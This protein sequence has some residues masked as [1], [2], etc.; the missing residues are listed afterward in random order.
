MEL[1]SVEINGFEKIDSPVLLEATTINHAVNGE[2]QTA[3]FTIHSDN[4]GANAVVG[5]AIVGDALVGDGIVV[6]SEI[7]VEA[8]AERIFAGRISQMKVEPKVGSEI[9]FILTCQDYTWLL[10][11]VVIDTSFTGQSDQDIIQSLFAANLPEISVS[12]AV[13]ISDLSIAFEDV[14][15]RGAMEMITERTGADWYV[16]FFKEL[17]YQSPGALTAPFGFSD[18]PNGVSTFRILREGFSASDD[19]ST[20]ANTVTVKGREQE[21]FV[22]LFPVPSGNDDAMILK[23]GATFPPGGA[24][25][26]QPAGAMTASRSW[27]GSSYEII[28]NALRF[29]T[30]AIP[31]DCIVTSAVLVVY[32]DAAFGSDDGGEFGIEYYDTA[33][34]PLD[35]A[36]YTDTAPATANATGYFLISNLTALGTYRFTLSNLSNI[37]KT[38]YTGF[39]CHVKVSGTPTGNNYTAFASQDH[40][41]AIRPVLEVHY[42]RPEMTG[43]YTDDA[44]VA[45][46]GTLS[47]T[48]IERSVE[49]ED[50]ANLRAEYETALHAFPTKLIT[51]NWD[52]DGIK[53]DYSV[54]IYHPIFGLDG[55]YVC[56]KLTMKW[57]T[58]SETLYQGEL[59]QP[60]PDLVRLIR[61]LTELQ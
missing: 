37:N 47:R 36:D 18:N 50:E 61:R 26:V 19:F 16:D 42:S 46:Y 49:T 34:W 29:D 45:L 57:T 4:Y 14:T 39:R 44:S 6:G 5:M 15:L 25:I 3:E 53:L 43:S 38:G 31:D 35:T 23:T 10:D 41:T 32:T 1:T 20:P 48:I 30:S 22:T 7:I 8:G 52:Q 17:Q 56:K 54:P 59:G 60:Q 55:N 28:I 40:T 9:L 2:I 24:A 21:D 51:M 12:A 58:K 11:T 27:N 13:V 33:N